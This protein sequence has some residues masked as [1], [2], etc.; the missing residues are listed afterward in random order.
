MT[1]P[2]AK[3]TGT[4]YILAKADGANVLVE[5]NEAN[6]VS[7]RILRVGPDLVAAARGIS[8]T[9]KVDATISVQDLTSN[10]S[11][12]TTPQSTTGYYLSTDNHLDAG[13]ILIGRRTVPALAAGG[14]TLAS[15]QAVIPGGTVPGAYYILAV[16]DYP[17]VIVESNE[18]NNANGLPITVVP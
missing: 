6:N 3:A 18:S 15:A 8:G 12:A 14:S 13:D 4:Y 5:K 16:A 10:P 1:I 2:A 17:K 7:A 11:A 9:P